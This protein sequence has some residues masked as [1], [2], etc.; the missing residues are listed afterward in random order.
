MSN[1]KKTSGLYNG[2]TFVIAIIAIV[3]L[4]FNMY[5]MSQG[6]TVLGGMV[7][8]TDTSISILNSF[9]AM[10]KSAE[11][12]D[13]IP[14]ILLTTILMLLTVIFTVIC[15]INLV[16]SIFKCFGFFKFKE[17]F[18]DRKR[19]FTR[20]LKKPMLGLGFMSQIILFSLFSS[21]GLLNK[22]KTLLIISCVF[23]GVVVIFQAL[24][25]IFNNEEKNVV[26]EIFEC[27]R[28]IFYLLIP[29]FFC[30]AVIKPSFLDMEAMVAGTG[31]GEMKDVYFGLAKVALEAA[32]CII[33]L[34]SVRKAFKLGFAERDYTRKEGRRTKNYGAGLA[35][36]A[37]VL[38]VF[39]CAYAYASVM[40]FPYNSLAFNNDALPALLNA[41]KTEYLWTYLL[42]L[43]ALIVTVFAGSKTATFKKKTA[44]ETVTENTAETE[45]EETQASE[46]TESVE[47]E[48]EKA[49]TSEKVEEVADDPIEN[50]FDT[51]DEEK[52]DE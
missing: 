13:S 3:L 46:E 9:L 16:I 30:F 51:T 27:V 20:F 31:T 10:T 49:Q 45:I 47:T 4:A 8:N 21:T 33:C 24:M 25:N 29:L 12:S 2:L 18:E 50:V 34:V 1:E 14:P 41:L 23:Y 40:V 17:E 38:F 37:I 22:G 6:V 43:A 39:V 5:S 44:E 52:K 26:D 15:F 19:R 35:V 7:F 32:L 36:R 28:K 11:S 48:T 42:I